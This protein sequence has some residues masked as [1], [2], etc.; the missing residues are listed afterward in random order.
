M[1]KLAGGIATDLLADEMVL[2]GALVCTGAFALLLTTSSSYGWMAALWFAAGLAQ[3]P[4]WPALANILMRWFQ[5]TS[6]G[7]MWGLLSTATN[8]GVSFGPMLLVLVLTSTGRWTAVFRVTGCALLLVGAAAF[9]ILIRARRRL[10]EV[11]GEDGGGDGEKEGGEMQEQEGAG[12]GERTGD[13][14]TAGDRRSLSRIFWE[15]VLFTHSFIGMCLANATVVFLVS[16][17][18]D[19]SNMFMH[20][21]FEL[22]KVG[23]GEGGTETFAG[24]G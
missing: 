21:S 8:V 24:A 13:K 9:A 3:G 1:S 20:E 2:C 11:K 18:S 6:I 19:W 22:S 23:E 14:A 16:V 17:L 7:S 12:G 5:P 4:A 10:P 15:D